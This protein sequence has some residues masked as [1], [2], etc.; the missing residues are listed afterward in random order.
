MSK[1]F[2]CPK[3]TRATDGGH[4]QR[5]V[6]AERGGNATEQVVDAADA[7]LCEHSG[8]V[9]GGVRDVVHGGEP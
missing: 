9:F 4:V 5:A 1:R 3:S 6:E 8:G 2:D 7:D